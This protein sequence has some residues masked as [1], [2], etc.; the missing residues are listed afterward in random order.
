M[1]CC[2]AAIC[3]AGKTLVMIADR[4][5]GIGIIQ[6][7]PDITKLR[8]VYKDCW[9]LFSGD[10][11]SP[12]F[13]II[14]LAKEHIRTQQADLERRVPLALAMEAVQEGYQ[15]KRMQEAE[16]LYLRP[17]GWDLGTFNATG[18][19][20][21]DFQEIKQRI[22]SYAIPIDLIVAGFAEEEA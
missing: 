22:E 11:I 21:P 18:T 3:D 17:I 4:M 9:V 16:S 13:D 15:K 20:L 2:V 8:A 10:D 5:I 7:E 12:V 19:A 14:D 1:T 6:S